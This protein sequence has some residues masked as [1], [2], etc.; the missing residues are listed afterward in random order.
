MKVSAKDLS[1][2]QQAAT[3]ADA[4]RELVESCRRGFGRSWHAEAG[5][6]VVVSGLVLGVAAIVAS[7]TM[8]QDSDLKPEQIV[9]QRVATA[10]ADSD[11][12]IEMSRGVQTPFAHRE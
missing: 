12:T 1:I 7:A 9:L 11:Q 3:V 2:L 5:I 8:P 10:S 6:L 4:Q